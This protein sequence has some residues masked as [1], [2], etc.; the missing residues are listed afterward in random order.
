[1]ER[2]AKSKRQAHRKYT[3]MALSVVDLIEPPWASTGAGNAEP[4]PR[5]LFTLDTAAGPPLK[6]LEDP[7]LF[8]WSETDTGIGDAEDS[9]DASLVQCQRDA[10]PGG[11]YRMPLSTR[12]TSSRRRCR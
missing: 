12:F 11:V 9:P 6:A 2:E 5:A 4:Q 3:A 7:S 8:L 10:P 1:M